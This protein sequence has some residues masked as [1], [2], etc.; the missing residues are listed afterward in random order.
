M[1]SLY[2]SSPTEFSQHWGRGG[3]CHH[4]PSPAAPHLPVVG[5]LWYRSL[6]CSLT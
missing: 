3:T 1:L 4:P 5:S 6:A 2:S